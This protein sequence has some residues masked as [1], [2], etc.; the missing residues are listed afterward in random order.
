[1]RLT[2]TD[3]PGEVA[4]EADDIAAEAAAAEAAGNIITAV[5]VGVTAPG[6]GG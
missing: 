1:M 4:A 2:G 3:C 6:T 5:A